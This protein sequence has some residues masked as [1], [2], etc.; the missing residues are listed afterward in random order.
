M[1]KFC[2]TFPFIIKGN[3]DDIVFGEIY[4]IDER[5]LNS[6]DSLESCPNFYERITTKDVDGEK[7]FVYILSDNYFNTLT[8]WDKIPS[9]IWK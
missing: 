4:E 6:L 1:G 3:E 7:L 8:Y 5:T 2:N 9:G